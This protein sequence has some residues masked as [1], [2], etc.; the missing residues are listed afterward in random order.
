MFRALFLSLLACLP[1]LSRAA[2]LPPP[3]P[4]PFPRGPG[5]AAAER[6]VHWTPT[7]FS[8]QIVLPRALSGPELD[9]FSAALAA[10]GWETGIAP[11]G[12]DSDSAFADTLRLLRAQGNAAFADGLSAL[13]ADGLVKWDKGPLS[14]FYFAGRRLL[15]C[16][17]PFSPECPAPSAAPGEWLFSTPLPL[18]GAEPVRRVVSLS[19]GLMTAAEIWRAPAAAGTLFADKARAQLVSCG[20]ECLPPGGPAPPAADKE[21]AA[22]DAALVERLFAGTAHFRSAAGAEAMLSVRGGEDGAA[23]CLFLLR[24]PA[25]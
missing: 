10:D 20:W 22:R 4:L 21:T 13:L 2:P 14:L 6:T 11:A 8:H 23:T 24:T 19:G 18:P 5:L 17:F 25:P 3:W 15:L 16:T 7:E 12:A 1:A 9:A